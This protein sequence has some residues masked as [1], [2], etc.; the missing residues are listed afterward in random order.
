MT[1]KLLK[2]KL[3][4]MICPLI[5]LGLS[6]WPSS[7]KKQDVMCYQPTEATARIGFGQRFLLDVDTFIDSV[8]VDTTLFFYRDTAMPYLQAFYDDGD[9]QFTVIAGEATNYL[10]LLLNPQ[11]NITR[12]YVSY[13]SASSALDTVTIYYETHPVFISNDCG[14]TNYYT[15]TDVEYASEGIDS[16]HINDKEVTLDNANNKRHINFYY[17]ND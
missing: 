1:V 12:Y 3:L 5:L 11:T 2:S 8:L 10:T 7:C 16:M 14:F 9:N 6:I 4:A 17:F 15:I 13:D